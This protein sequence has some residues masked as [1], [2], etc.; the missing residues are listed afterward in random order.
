MHDLAL[1][2]QDLRAGRLDAAA[3]C[4]QTFLRAH[5]AHPDA[6]NLLAVICAQAGA[7]DRALELAGQA[8]AARPRESRYRFNRAMIRE[9]AGDNIG[10]EADYRAAVECDSGNLPAGINLGNL[11]LRTDRMRDA[12][13]CFASAAAAFPNAAEAH[14]GLGV[15]LRHQ[16]RD[17][18]ALAALQRAL[19]LSPRNPRIEANIAWVLFQADRP[20]DAVRYFE[21]ALAAAPDIADLWAGLAAAHMRNAAWVDALAALDRALT[22]APGHTRALAFKGVAL[23]ALGRSD[24]RQKLIDLDRILWERQFKEPPDGYADLPAFNQALANHALDHPTL[25]HNRPTKTTR[26]GSQTD[27]L[28]DTDRGPVAALER[29]MRAAVAAYLEHATRNSA[30]PSAPPERW[31]LRAWATVLSAGGYQ[32]PHNHPTGWISGVYYVQVP[33]SVSDDDPDR[34]GWIEF[35]RPD[36]FLRPAGVPDLRFFRPCEGLMLIFPS[37]VWH[38]TIPYSGDRPRI[39]IAFDVI[40]LADRHHQD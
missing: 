12:E 37:Y 1:A 10:A 29:W 14:E 31:R 26:N 38:R 18:D 13:A 27:G 4:C 33:P 35:G 28:L 7:T 8:I 6:L 11:L 2:E 17:D 19:S 24:E 36:P 39:S 30:P 23:D 9:A 34:A 40:P 3:R 21:C 32:D 16:G 5:P 22:L 20:R 25:A 15:A